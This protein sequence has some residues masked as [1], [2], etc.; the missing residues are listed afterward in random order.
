MS[1]KKWSRGE[2]IE[3]GGGKSKEPFSLKQTQ[4]KPYKRLILVVSLSAA[5]FSGSALAISLSVSTS[6]WQ[7]G[8]WMD[9]S[10]FKCLSMAQN[11]SWTSQWTEHAGVQYAI[12]MVPSCSPLS[13]ANP[14]CDRYPYR[15]GGNIPACSSCWANSLMHHIPPKGRWNLFLLCRILLPYCNTGAWLLIMSGT[16]NS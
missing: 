4:L 15:V 12:V 1:G 3:E 8:N 10:M 9:L 6:W 2:E 16:A 11:H 5:V 14:P 13:A 7:R